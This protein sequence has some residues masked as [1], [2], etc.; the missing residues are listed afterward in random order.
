MWSPISLDELFDL[1]GKSEAELSSTEQRLWELIRIPTEKWALSPWGDEG[2]GFWVVG[3]LGRHVVWYNDIEDGFNVSGY[4]ARG[5]IGQYWCN[6][7]ALKPVL[8]N[9]LRRIE[10]GEIPGAAGP[11]QPLNDP[12]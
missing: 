4:L 3:L 2:G 11:P 5:T 9:L 7:D 12:A 1:I 8:W 10:T 6:Q